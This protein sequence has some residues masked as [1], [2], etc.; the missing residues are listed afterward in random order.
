MGRGKSVSGQK[1]A[2]LDFPVKR[3]DNHVRARLGD[4]RVSSKVRFI[5]AAAL[6]ELFDTFIEDCRANMTE[7]E[8]AK[9][10]VTIKA[11]HCAKALA[12]PETPYANLFPTH[13]AGVY[14]EAKKE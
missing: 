14:A 12:N 4:V 13:V 11:S 10:R 9:D 7:K 8:L 6:N 1:R 2:G 5:V 3:I